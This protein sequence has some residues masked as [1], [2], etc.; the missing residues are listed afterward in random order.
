MPGIPGCPLQGDPLFQGGCDPHWPVDDP[1]L[2]RGDG[3]HGR[4]DHEH[5]RENEGPHQQVERPQE[6][7][8]LGRLPRR[9]AGEGQVPL[10]VGDAGLGNLKVIILEAS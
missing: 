6:A 2:G 7:E 10:R 3:E 8:V 5:R 1:H 9:R 4:A